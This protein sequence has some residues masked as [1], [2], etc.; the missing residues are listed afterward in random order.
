MT[1]SGGAA[2]KAKDV[3]EEAKDSIPVAVLKKIDSGQSC[4]GVASE[5]AWCC[6]SLSTLIF[7][8]TP[9]FYTIPIFPLI[10]QKTS[11][12]FVLST[13]VLSDIQCTCT[14]TM[15]MYRLHGANK[16]C[17]TSNIQHML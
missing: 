6:V 8:A 4:R 11:N 9:P 15:I 2:C 5:L 12:L 17:C 10:N 1:R 13:N 14:S 3:F 16:P 7:Q